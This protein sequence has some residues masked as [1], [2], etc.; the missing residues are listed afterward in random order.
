VILCIFLL[1][2]AAIWRNESSLL[3]LAVPHLSVA[4]STE[5]VS[6]TAPHWPHSRHHRK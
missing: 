2:S 6:C 3:A 5:R 1:I 4:T